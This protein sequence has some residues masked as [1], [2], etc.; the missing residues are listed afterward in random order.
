MENKFQKTFRMF[1][2]TP[3]NIEIDGITYM[4]LCS[5]ITRKGIGC[6]AYVEKL[7]YNIVLFFSNDVSII[8]YFTFIRE[9]EFFRY[10]NLNIDPKKKSAIYHCD[11]LENYNALPDKA[12][13]Y[14]ILDYIFYGNNEGS[15]LKRVIF[16]KQTAEDKEM[17]ENMK[18]YCF[19][20]QMPENM[21][22]YLS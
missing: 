17:L 19:S 5:F 13:K 7:G 15:L 16:A 2:D 21:R 18:K 3:D 11:I 10:M 14:P 9:K 12:D 1:H 6:M 8:G 20:Y 22:K 4:P